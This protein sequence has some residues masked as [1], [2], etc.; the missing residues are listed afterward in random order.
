ML[1]NFFKK[2]SDHQESLDF[3]ITGKEFINGVG[4]EAEE[5]V[6]RIYSDFSNELKANSID[7]EFKKPIEEKN[8]GRSADWPFAVVE[9][10][11][12]NPYVKAAA[13]ASG[14]ITLGKHVISFFSKNKENGIFLG[15]DSG[16]MY[17]AAKLSEDINILNIIT[18]S[19][20]ELNRSDTGFDAREY[21]YVFGI[22]ESEYDVQDTANKDSYFKGDI[23]VV[24]LSWEGTVINVTKY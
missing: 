17:A 20:F 7:S 19:Q 12:T 18:L 11:A 10:L 8:Y 2:N 14:L 13:T 21:L 9:F 6:N 23:Y 22:N 16:R 5:K 4:D 3:L 1:C 24:H 15:I